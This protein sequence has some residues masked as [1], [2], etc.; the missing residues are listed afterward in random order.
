MSLRSV[1]WDG[2][3]DKLTTNSSACLA[4]MSPRKPRLDWIKEVL[5]DF[6]NSDEGARLAP[7]ETV[8][9]C[10]AAPDGDDRTA[11]PDSDDPLLCPCWQLMRLSA[12]QKP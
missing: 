6:D 8:G 7:I 12:A 4:G 10:E 1:S 3:S 11:R 2:R 5:A 9:E